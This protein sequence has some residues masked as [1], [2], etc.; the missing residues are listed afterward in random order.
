[1]GSDGNRAF[2]APPGQGSRIFATGLLAKGAYRVDQV[3]SATAK[4]TSAPSGIPL[5]LAPL[6]SPYRRHGQ[7]SLRI[8]RVPD[9]ARFSRGSNNGDTSWSLTMDELDGLVYL[10]PAG[11]EAPHTLTVRIV[12]HEDDYGATLAVVDLPV[13]RREPSAAATPIAPAVPPAR[14]GGDAAALRRLRAELT[15][16]KATLAAR[17]ADLAEARQE[18]E[19]VRADVAQ[20]TIEARLID[21]RIAWEAE[22]EQRFANAEQSAQ[23]RIQQ[24]REYGRQEAGTALAQAEKSWNAGEAARL[25]AA[26]AQWRA[27]SALALAQAMGRVDQAE[28]A[29]A[30]AAEAWKAKAADRLAAAQAQW[31]DQS[32]RALAEAAGRAERAEA[33][34]AE[35]RAEIGREDGERRSLRGELAAARALLAAREIELTEPQRKVEHAQTE[36]SQQTIEARLAEAR[37]AWEV[38]AERR[39]AAA[40]QGAQE[41]LHQAHEHWQQ[42]AGAALAKAEEAWKASEAIR[43]VTAEARWRDRSARALAEAIERFERAEAALAETHAQAGREDAERHNLRAEL[44]EA[45]AALAARDS[46]LSETRQRVEHVPADVA[47]P[48]IEA[49]LVDARLAWEAE[50]EQRLANAE[51]QAKERIQHAREHGR[52]E[53]GGALAKAEQA[54]KAG[55]ARRLAAAEAQWREQSEQVLGEA[56]GRVEQAE[57][58]LAEMRAQTERDG[59][60]L[61]SLRGGL[62]E[63]TAALAA[64]EAELAHARSVAAATAERPTAT[65]QAAPKRTVDTAKLHQAQKVLADLLR[66]KTDADATHLPRTPAA[67]RQRR[68][69][70]RVIGGGALLAASAMTLML[71]L[72]FEPTISEG[73]ESVVAP[74]AAEIE[75][76]FY[77]ADAPVQRPVADRVPLVKRRTVIDVPVAN[78]RAGPSPT[79]AVVTTLTRDTEVTP[80][81]HH[82]KWV[83]VRVGGSDGAR[84]QEG[85]VYEASLSDTPGPREADGRRTLP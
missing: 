85:W 61:Q 31:R 78:L 34:L 74:L 11:M 43:F 22:V 35:A 71:Y 56:T 48:T 19:H 82:G 1:M 42:E 66:R 51:Q 63:A 59:A 46:E 70:R 30:T 64:R 39:L 6:L 32:A 17:E 83:L 60:E 15:E 25:A 84:R 54:W 50:V 4:A 41:R 73:W 7:L 2:R 3:S 40:E 37:T 21:A 75:R 13:S 10:P 79:A 53:A 26:E 69:R 20:Q 65:L 16:V 18:V 29:L 44:A 38:E 81:E 49:R 72:H 77:K 23:E 24:A 47:Q 55:E 57:T 67:E 45:K 68:S 58:A 27:Q 33:A 76:S 9:R 5:E 12:N 62:T 36:V 8:E 80:L 28:A 52:Q 14:D